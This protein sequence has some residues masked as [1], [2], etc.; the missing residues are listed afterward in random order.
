MHSKSRLP[1]Q[2]ADS[3]TR[4]VG[5]SEAR[6]EVV[7]QVQVASLLHAAPR[8]SEGLLGHLVQLLAA[9]A[10]VVALVGAQHLLEDVLVIRRVL[11]RLGAVDETLDLTAGRSEG[12]KAIRRPSRSP[13]EYQDINDS[14]RPTD[15]AQTVSQ[16]YLFIQ[17]YLTHKQLWK[18][19]ARFKKF[20]NS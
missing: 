6:A 10:Q 13:T 2:P 8:L 15:P 19:F 11:L 20:L 5:V 18:A 17:S 1:Q 3:L 14:A 9:Q 16:L 7:H 12:K 4:L